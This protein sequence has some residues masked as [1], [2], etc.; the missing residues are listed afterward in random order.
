[1]NANDNDNDPQ[2]G[3]R[4]KRQLQA[5]RMRE[6]TNNIFVPTDEVPWILANHWMT[7]T[8][9]LTADDPRAPNPPGFKGELY[10]PQATM[11]QA[12][13]DMERRPVLRLNMAGASDDA[14]L[15]IMMANRGLIREQFSFGKTV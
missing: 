6:N 2:L 7:T 1:M 9:A 5:R 8:R 3:R 11:L 13:L 15:P 14:R 10:L 12:M 4:A